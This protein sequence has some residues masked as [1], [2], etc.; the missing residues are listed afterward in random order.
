MMEKLIGCYG[1]FRDYLMF[2][3]DIL[4]IKINKLIKFLWLIV[5]GKYSNDVV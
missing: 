2:W 5:V 1:M 4:V 3:W